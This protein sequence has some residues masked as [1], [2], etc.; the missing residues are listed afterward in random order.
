MPQIIFGSDFPQD[1]SDLQVCH[2]IQRIKNY[3]AVG[4]TVVLVHCEAMF[5]SLYDLLNQHYTTHGDQRYVRLAFGTYTR[6]C[7]VHQDF[8]VVVVVD[9]T[10]AY[11]KLAAP[12]LN[13]FEKQVLERQHIL[14]PE[15][16]KVVAELERFLLCFCTA[17]E[18]PKKADQAGATDGKQKH[19]NALRA[20]FCGYHAD[21]LSSLALLVCRE[22]T[23]NA[24][25]AA[26]KQL[27]WIATPEAVCVALADGRKDAIAAEFDL[28]LQEEYFNR[29]RHGNLGGFASVLNSADGWAS[30]TKGSVSQVLTY[31][32]LTGRAGSILSESAGCDGGVTTIVLHDLTSERD[33][34]NAV[35]GFFASAATNSLLLVQCDPLAASLRRIEHAK[36]I[37]EKAHDRAA[38]SGERRLHVMV[39]LHL[40]RVSDQSAHSV[41]FS[42]KWRLA[43]VDSVEAQDDSGLPDLAEMIGRPMSELVGMVNLQRVLER[44]FRGAMAKL[45]YP[46]THTYSDVQT[47]IRL[48]LSHLQHPEFLQCVREEM[49]AIVSKQT[50]AKDLTQL[51][52]DPQ[53]L[54]QSGTFQAAMR[55]QVIGAMLSLFAEMMAHMDRNYGIAL[56]AEEE[57]ARDGTELR[58]MWR[59]LFHL[60]FRERANRIN[61]GELQ[62]IVDV[63]TDEGI[64]LSAS[65][66]K[67]LEDAADM[68]FQFPFSF[69]I[70]S[71]IEGMQ[72]NA[73]MAGDAGATAFV[74]QQLDLQNWQHGLGGDLSEALMRRYVYDFTCMNT[75]AS[76]AISRKDQAEV[77][78]QAL[79][80][81]AG[82]SLV[83]LAAVHGT[84]WGVKQALHLYFQL[85]DAIPACAPALTAFLQRLDAPID[86]ATHLGVLRIV[87]PE[88]SP[89]AQ[90][91]A[92]T[93]DYFKCVLLIEKVRKTI[94]GLLDVCKAEDDVGGVTSAFESWDRI[95][96]SYRF[97]RDFAQPLAVEAPFAASAL[98]GLPEEGVRT[99]PTFRGYLRL[100]ES[101]RGRCEAAGQDAQMFQRCAST[102]LHFFLFDMCFPAEQR[103]LVAP[104]HISLLADL[105]VVLAGRAVDGVGTL[106]FNVLHSEASRVSVL[107]ALLADERA[108][109][110]DTRAE[111]TALVEQELSASQK[112]HGHLDTPLLCSYAYYL[113]ERLTRAAKHGAAGEAKGQPRPV[114]AAQVPLL[115]QHELGAL[116]QLGLPNALDC[117]ARVR[118]LLQN[119]AEA[120]VLSVDRPEG[121]GR[122]RGE[123]QAAALREEVELVLA[124]NPANPAG[125][126][127]ARMYLLKCLER[128]GG[129]LSFVRSCLQQ[130]PLISST[131]VQQWKDTTESAFMRFIGS[132]KL[133][134][135]NPMRSMKLYDAFAKAVAIAWGLSGDL[136]PLNDL[137]KQ[138]PTNAGKGAL[139]AA[140]FNVVYLCRVLPDAKEGQGTVM[141]SRAQ[142]MREWVE[143]ESAAS[144][145]SCC[146][147][148]ERA[149]LGMFAGSEKGF[150]DSE[151]LDFLRLSPESTPERIL[152]VR[153]VAH[154][155]A[156]ALASPETDLLGFFKQLLLE[157]KKVVGTLWPTMPED[158]M[159]QVLAALYGG[160][161]SG[162]GQAASQFRCCPQPE[163]GEIQM[164]RHCSMLHYHHGQCP[165]F[166]TSVRCSYR[167]TFDEVK[168]AAD[169]AIESG[170]KIPVGTVLPKCP[171]HNKTV[172]FSGCLSGCGRIF[173]GCHFPKLSK[174]QGDGEK[175]DFIDWGTLP[176]WA[177]T[178]SD[179]ETRARR[180][181]CLG[182][183]EQEADPHHTERA[184]HVRSLRAIRVVLHG[185]LLL[186][187]AAGGETWARDTAGLFDEKKDKQQATPLADLAVSFTAQFEQDWG[188][189]RSGLDI[190]ADEIEVCMHKVVQQMCGAGLAV[191][192]RLGTLPD[193]VKWE[194]AFETCGAR[195]FML[196]GDLKEKLRALEQEYAGNEADEEQGAFVAELNEEG[197]IG[198]LPVGERR[199]SAP[200]LWMYRPPFRFGHFK[201]KVLD[202]STDENPG[203]ESKHALLALFVR[204][205]DLLRGL[206]HLSHAFEFVRLCSKRYGRRLTRER[207]RQLTVAEAIAE[208][209]AA[210]RALWDHA[211]SGFRLAWNR[212][213]RPDGVKPDV[214]RFHWYFGCEALANRLDLDW[215]SKLVE[216]LPYD[217]TQPDHQEY[218][219]GMT[220][221]AMLFSNSADTS[222][223]RP[224]HNT[225][226]EAVQRVVGEA[227][228]EQFVHCD[229]FSGVH[230]LSCDFEGSFLP[231]VEQLCVAHALG[232]AVEYDFTGAERYLSSL[233]VS[234]PQ[235]MLEASFEYLDEK[236]VSRHDMAEVA[237][238]IPQEKLARQASDAILKE[239]AQPAQAQ[240]CLEVLLTCISFLATTGKG[241]G[242]ASAEEAGTTLARYAAEALQ[243]TE[244]Q[245]GSR[246]I[247][248]HVQLRHL[249][250][251]QE[252]LDGLA[253]N[254]PLKDVNFK[255]RAELDA[256]GAAR[257]RAAAPLM[258]LDQVVSALMEMLSE[259][260]GGENMSGTMGVTGVLDYVEVDTGGGEMEYMSELVGY[261]EHFPKD[262]PMMYAVDVY[263]L[264][265][266]LLG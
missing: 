57:A 179:G 238:R 149:L 218:P 263:T 20:A 104:L 96:C 15:H 19:Q 237:R 83:R 187:A 92:G 91:W 230:T 86:T 49:S 34:T 199:L 100:L 173:H 236:K 59:Y 205:S 167:A 74:Q 126:R 21:L 159:A 250:H 105:S 228:Q 181:Y 110:A 39:L 206:P 164:N 182:T 189:M 258:E 82:G 12:L 118:L 63:E 115:Q 265:S 243:M 51:A 191:A 143:D 221:Y 196:E 256:A 97:V 192:N 53:Q 93:S 165:D 202:G 249:S 207:A 2:N 5:E 244:E 18:E 260:C 81:G 240:A 225:L 58:G 166:E 162:A 217:P 203:V 144:A 101:C 46:H 30:D 255:Y 266:E 56:Y 132:D 138:N 62:P 241:S 161:G 37:C 128:R 123:E 50:P 210:Q 38:A 45:K 114:D 112:T 77:V 184:L 147:A 70:G 176:K 122:T 160:A 222:N 201:N 211:F 52:A 257:L 261:A 61:V 195:D 4:T 71:V 209:P 231:F 146:S 140:L 204:N 47:D 190:N 102:F 262:I 55:R 170:G 17:P 131:W 106:R 27:L 134:K 193:R 171:T 32:P 227:S 145:L 212:S 139:L 245:L 148:P 133:P 233:W 80:L 41:D 177:P 66:R 116:D 65:A 168:A 213:R 69:H 76:A 157:P 29:Q 130:A 78:W 137:L 64:F 87:L 22:G 79:R 117:V 98:D 185:A 25:A 224:S 220:A 216:C 23:D 232:G 42:S 95:L 8:R 150:A 186:G 94:G 198:G 1:K 109:T 103:A 163:C 226:V 135:G 142:M 155:A 44:E 121:A 33:M 24:V 14:T 111:I 13:R 247:A 85:M 156:A 252:L 11:T 99:Q 129:G 178:G 124:K 108:F 251:L 180:N 72:E 125:A 219:E 253:S 119:Y 16:K 31:S 9:R 235:I 141:S 54:E 208:Q 6:P 223:E 229:D 200:A 248:T 234:K 215:D 88:L 259:Y 89:V 7:E 35:E 264:L 197:N 174:R 127:S 214:E 68:H 84:H 75:I 90:G 242:E 26:I 246:A 158:E 107:R 172:L 67:M 43:F 40:P 239:V 73:A 175:R 151:A 254:D 152:M 113:E 10:E 48:I 153:L 36:F 120:L 194:A 3:M 136:K 169:V 28:D 60:S 183:L 154:V 188:L